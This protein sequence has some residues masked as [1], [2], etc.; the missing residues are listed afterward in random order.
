M[1]NKLE[2]NPAYAG[3][4]EVLSTDLIS[5]FQWVGITGAPKTFSLT[6][7]SPLRNRH[8]GLGFSAYRDALGPTVD[9]NIMGTFAYRIIFPTTKLCFG[10][11]AGIKYYDIDW[12]LL[13][14]KDPGDVELNNQVKNKVVPDADF[15]IYYYGK[16]FYVGVSS[17]HLL[18][19]QITTSSSP[20]NDK[21]SFTKLYRHFYGLAGGAIPLREDII[22]MPS[23]LIK[24][25][26]NAPFQLDL[27][28]SFMF[29]NN[30][31]L[32]A[33]YRSDQAVGLILEVNLGKGFSLGYSYDIWF[34]SLKAQNQGSHEIR[35]GYDIDLFEKNRMLSPRYF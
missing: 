19:N 11:S 28:G 18:Q 24:Y 12:G 2:F 5:R 6:A 4:S 35:I 17:K 16:Y 32:G 7:H 13:N 25:V 8:I 29:Y 1:Y 27:T 20:T 3:S 23:L 33:T 31:V 14:P 9:Y 30:L 15:G 22:F 34:N 10:I 26:Q 21:V